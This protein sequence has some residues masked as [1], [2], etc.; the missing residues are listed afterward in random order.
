MQLC[1]CVYMI[2]F[3]YV[4]DLRDSMEEECATRRWEIEFLQVRTCSLHVN[5]IRMLIKSRWHA[6][7]LS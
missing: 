4:F 2:V 3:Y 6:R 7:V 1:V 5:K